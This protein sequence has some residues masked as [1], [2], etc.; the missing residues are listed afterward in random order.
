[1]MNKQIQPKLV[2]ITRNDL[3]A[4]YQSVQPAHAVAQFAVDHYDTFKKWDAES[5]YIIIL[6]ANDLEHLNKQIN[7]INHLNVDF[8]VFNEP[9]IQNHTTAVCFY[10]ETDKA[11]K[12][13]S[14]LPLVLKNYRSLV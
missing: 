6:S 11:I 4:G 2:V 9:D 13:F 12:M 7:K 8:S 5:K 10:A 14:H 3:S 1:M